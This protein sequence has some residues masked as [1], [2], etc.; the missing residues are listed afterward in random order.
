VSGEPSGKTIHNVY[1]KTRLTP[2]RTPEGN[3]DMTYLCSTKVGSITRGIEQ[4]T[5]GYD[6]SLVTAV[7]LG[8]TMS[9]SLAYV[10]NNDFRPTRFTYAGGSVD[11][12]YDN[13]GLLTRA[14]TSTIIR[15]AQNGLSETV[16]GGALNLSRTFNG[17]GE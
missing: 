4:I 2:I 3:I 13:D 10:Y 11:Y 1:D 8:G 9:Q 12:T 16:T 6:G 5:Y 7:A 17:Y 15:N 14:G